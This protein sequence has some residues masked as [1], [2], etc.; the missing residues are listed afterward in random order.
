LVD[1]LIARV[2]GTDVKVL[3]R[4][5]RGTGKEVVARAIHNASPRRSRPF[6]KV[7]CAAPPQML[8]PELFGWTRGSAAGPQHRPGRLDFA[9]HGTL[10]LDHV[11]ELPPALQLRLESMLGQAG[12]E[13]TLS[14]GSIPGNVRFMASSDRD[15]QQAV[16]E[17]RFREGLLFHLNGVCLT[18]SPLRQRRAELREL[19]EFFV[20]R[21]AKHYNKPLVPLSPDTI[22]LFSEHHWPGNL[23]ELETVIMRLVLLGSDAGARDELTRLTMDPEQMGA[24]ARETR[25]SAP[26]A[27]GAPHATPEL[28]SVTGPLPLKE[29]AR[30]A[31][32]DAERALIVT[33]LQRTRWNRRE[34]AASLGVSYKALLYKIKRAETSGA[35]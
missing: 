17:G 6:I 4:G 23:K 31:A 30:Q 16:A 10:F 28:P 13:G 35:L 14:S 8:E 32:D 22:Q 20:R 11:L 24:H 15:L 12:L 27:A 18:L 26:V 21:Y 34:A 29:I 9:Q 5:E 3:L 19:A 25:R 2:A 33:T 1:P 7:D